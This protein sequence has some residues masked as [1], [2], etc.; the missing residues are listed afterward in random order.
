M[1]ASGGNLDEVASQE[2]K[3]EA[4]SSKVPNLDKSLLC[5]L[6]VSIELTSIKFS[7]FIGCARD[8]GG[9]NAKTRMAV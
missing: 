1:T 8:A 4:P 3:Q 2:V 7:Y 9:G 6:K 5:L